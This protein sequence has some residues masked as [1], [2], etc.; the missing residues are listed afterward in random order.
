MRIIRWRKM[1]VITL[2]NVEVTGASEYKQNV[3]VD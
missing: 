2:G 3:V 1:N